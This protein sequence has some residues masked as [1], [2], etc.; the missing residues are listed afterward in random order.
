MKFG[1]ES[2]IKRIS[3]SKNETV[4]DIISV[5]ELKKQD[6][7][8]DANDNGIFCLAPW[9]RLF[10]GRTNIVMPVCH[11]DVDGLRID[12]ESDLWNG[13]TMVYFREQILKKSEPDQCK[14]FCQTSGK[15]F[16]NIRRT[17]K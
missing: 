14:T 12:D 4:N 3:L 16:E 10:I 2:N 11:C 17:G 13:N 7:E 5:R 6:C 1:V 9:K 15:V 8:T